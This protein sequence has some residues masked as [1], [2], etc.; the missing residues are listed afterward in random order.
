M[1]FMQVRSFR[2]VGF[3]FVVVVFFSLSVF[4]T[5]KIRFTVKANQECFISCKCDYNCVVVNIVVILTLCSATVQFVNVLPF[6]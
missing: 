2:V 1:I 3:S 5:A 6:I 4:E